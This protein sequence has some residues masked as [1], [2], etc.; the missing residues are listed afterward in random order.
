MSPRI[1]SGSAKGRKLYSLP[2]NIVRPITDRAKEALFDILGP[3]VFGATMLDL[4]AGIGGVGL[5]AL[6]RGAAFV[7]FTEW[8]PK[9]VQVLRRNLKHC[10][11][12]DPQRAEVLHMDAFALLTHPADRAFDYI[13]IAPPQYK[14]LWKKALLLV[15]EHPEWLAEDG[16]VI[17]QIHPNEYENVPLKHLREFDQRR[18]GSVLLVFYE[19]GAPGEA[20]TLPQNTQQA[21]EVGAHGAGEP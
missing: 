8:N 5:E 1:I 11:L 9:V 16:W 13:F 7:R 10:G 14:G 20:T 17:V 3:D 18:Y 12:D 4:F 15:D 21:G 6:S 2:G 19:R